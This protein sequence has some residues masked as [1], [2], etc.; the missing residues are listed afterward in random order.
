MLA[1]VSL[2]DYVSVLA[3]ASVFRLLKS[4][5]DISIYLTNMNTL[6]IDIIAFFHS[7]DRTICLAISTLRIHLATTTLYFV[8]SNNYNILE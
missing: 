1:G 4:M 8:H 6:Q 7:I 2:L 3:C 5:S